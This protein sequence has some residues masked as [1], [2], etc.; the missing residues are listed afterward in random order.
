MYG[1]IPYNT[2]FSKRCS[3]DVLSTFSLRLSENC[4]LWTY[5]NMIGYRK[6]LIGHLMKFYDILRY[7]FGI[8]RMLLTGISVGSSLSIWNNFRYPQDKVCYVGID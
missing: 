5:L 1:K 3:K 7:L 8:S 6:I 2:Q 4:I